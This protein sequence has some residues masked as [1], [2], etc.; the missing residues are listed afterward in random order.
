MIEELEIQHAQTVPLWASQWSRESQSR[1]YDSHF[2]NSGGA[3]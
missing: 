3:Q 2:T 1:G